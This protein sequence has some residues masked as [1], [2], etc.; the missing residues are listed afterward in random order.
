MDVEDGCGSEHKRTTLNDTH[1]DQKPWHV[2]EDIGC[3]SGSEK[4]ILHRTNVEEKKK[5]SCQ[6]C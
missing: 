4:G 3:G 2:Q 5:P 6:S 1:H